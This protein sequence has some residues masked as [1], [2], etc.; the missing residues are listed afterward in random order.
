MIR[1]NIVQKSSNKVS[2]LKQE[3]NGLEY[4]ALGDQRESQQN[5]KKPIISFEF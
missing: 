5:T 3:I 4:Y 1:G 2:K